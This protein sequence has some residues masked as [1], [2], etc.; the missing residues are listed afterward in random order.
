MSVIVVFV[1]HVRQVN[2]HFLQ[3]VCKLPILFVCFFAL[4]SKVVMN[5]RNELLLGN[6]LSRSLVLWLVDQRP[7]WPQTIHFFDFPNFW[8]ESCS[9]HDTW[10]DEPQSWCWR[11]GHLLM[12][13]SMRACLLR[14]QCA[15]MTSRLGQMAQDCDK[16]IDNWRCIRHNSITGFEL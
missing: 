2:C 11:P 3:P 6:A 1:V 8:Y 12:T 10:N 13:C 5:W 7:I 4:S 9:A 14:V 15:S 16:T